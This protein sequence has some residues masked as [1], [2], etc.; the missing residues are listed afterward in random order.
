MEA[1]IIAVGAVYFF[2]I[3]RK[4]IRNW[5]SKWTDAEVD[6]KRMQGLYLKESEK[7][8]AKQSTKS[9]GA[10]MSR[11]DRRDFEAHYEGPRDWYDYTNG[12]KDQ[13]E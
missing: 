1:I 9:T 7:Q 6:R 2:L 11:A 10:K 4:A 8:R 3:L 12:P 5:Q 13:D